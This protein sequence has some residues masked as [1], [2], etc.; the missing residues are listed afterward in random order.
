M[1]E[2][3]K[4]MILELCESSDWEWKEHIEGVVKY[5]KILAEKTGADSEAV[6]LAAWLH[7]ITK[8]RDKDPDHSLTGS[9]KAEEILKEMGY[10]DEIIKK[11]S[12]CILKHSSRAGRPPETKEEKILYAADALSHFD[13]FLVHAR[14]SFV[15]RGLDVEEARERLKQKYEKYWKKAC[16][17][18]EAEELGRKKHEGIMLILK[19]RY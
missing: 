1:I 2:K 3:I 16:I 13:M 6:E 14:T 7:D 5:S 4:S 19:N 9:R 11:V 17:M 8:I 12:A 10:S 18:P 15:K